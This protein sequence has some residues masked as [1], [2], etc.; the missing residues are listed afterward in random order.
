[1][2]LRPWEAFRDDDSGLD[3]RSRRRRLRALVAVF[4]VI[5]TVLGWLGT[6]RD[7]AP[8]SAERATHRRTAPA[9]AMPRPWPVDP[10]VARVE[11]RARSGDTPKAAAAAPGRRTKKR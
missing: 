11:A 6:H 1:M 8:R 3:V 7:S 4:A 5:A 10:I 2:R 9:A